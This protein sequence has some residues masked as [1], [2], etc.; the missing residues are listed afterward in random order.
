MPVMDQ[1][2]QLAGDRRHQLLAHA[3]QQR[4]AERLLALAQAIRRAERAER[5]L[6]RSALATPGGWAPSSRPRPRTHSNRRE[7]RH[8]PATPGFSN[9]HQE[10][11]MNRTRRT[12]PIRR[13]AAILAGLTAAMLAAAAAAPAAFAR[14]APPV[15]TAPAGASPAPVHLP[16][17]P[18]GWNKH[19]PPG[20]AHV[21]GALAGGMP[22]W[23]IALIVAGAAVFAAVLVVLAGRMRARG[24]ATASTT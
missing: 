6:R 1:L 7:R 14:P 2:I 20:P 18:P 12:R 10:V 17:L 15:G 23:Q 21:H 4:P 19:P 3:D 9:D 24:R 11:I 16:P 8:Q 22:G 5:R 13:L